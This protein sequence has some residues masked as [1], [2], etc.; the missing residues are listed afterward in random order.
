MRTI[1]E[2]YLKE[3][4]RL[5][6]ERSR[7]NNELRDS[8][9]LED[10]CNGVFS[11]GPAKTNWVKAAGLSEVRLASYSLKVASDSYNK[12]IP[13]SELSPYFKAKCR[14]LVMNQYPDRKGDIR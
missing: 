11:L 7:L 6:N 12:E 13:Y 5:A 3:S 8:M 14:K 4:M 2:S 9:E 10:M 1:V